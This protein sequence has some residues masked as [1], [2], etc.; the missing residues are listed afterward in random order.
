MQQDILAAQEDGGCSMIAGEKA[1]AACEYDTWSKCY[2]ERLSQE[3]AP[4]YFEHGAIWQGV[5]TRDPE[6][7]D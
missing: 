5:H 7:T 2:L 3:A 6:L 4:K 1:L